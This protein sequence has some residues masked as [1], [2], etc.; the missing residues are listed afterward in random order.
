MFDKILSFIAPHYC[1]GCDKIG[2]LFCDN[3]KYNIISEQKMVCINCHRPTS[4]MYLCRDCKTPYEK[5]WIVGERT[6][7]LQRLI[8]LCKFERA[9]AGC[10]ILSDLLDDIL[11]ILPENTLIVPIPTT[12]SRIRERGYDHMF[13][14]A[15]YLAKK[16]QL[17]CG[18]VLKRTKNT[19]QRQANA[20]QR[21]SQAKDL[22]VVD[23]KLDKNT[24]YLLVDDVITSGATIKYA[25]QA[26]KKAGAKH[27]WV[28]V[29]ARQTLK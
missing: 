13:L 24:V 29:V 21:I 18:Q 20:R 15:R 14:V 1:C 2:S 6:G 22:F 12:E 26:L 7:P 23:K 27:V 3:C 8:G 17:A 16:R 5:A 28:A 19:K 25:S 4:S 9:I 10:K 11:P